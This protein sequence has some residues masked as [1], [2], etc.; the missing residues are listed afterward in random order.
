MLS[1]FSNSSWKVYVTYGLQNFGV[2]SRRRDRAVVLWKRQLLLLKQRFGS[3]DGCCGSLSFLPFKCPPRTAKILDSAS[4]GNNVQ[5]SVECGGSKHTSHTALTREDSVEDEDFVSISVNDDAGA[6]VGNARGDFCRRG[7]ERESVVV[8]P[9]SS[10]C[11]VLLY[12]LC[13]P[14]RYAL[15]FWVPVF[16]SFVLSFGIATSYCVLNKI[17]LWSPCGFETQVFLRPWLIE[18][19]APLTRMSFRVDS[20]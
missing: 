10:T 6:L 15:A 19:S 9:V 14:N 5:S 17:S 13:L 11:A 12:Q 1:W 3:G 4:S 20:S 18:K 16:R 8:N 2:P 7:D